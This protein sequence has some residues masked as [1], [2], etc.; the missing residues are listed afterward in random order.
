MILF[1]FIGKGACP[2]QRLINH[3]PDEKEE[4]ITGLA[5]RYSAE[6]AAPH[7]RASKTVPNAIRRPED[8]MPARD[9][10]HETASRVTQI[11]TTDHVT[12]LTAP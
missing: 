8:I 12:H 9:P 3:R 1:Q 6:G 10:S 5:G 4:S 7:W 2:Q 11:A